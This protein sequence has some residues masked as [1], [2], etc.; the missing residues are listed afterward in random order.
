MPVSLY[1][2]GR[3]AKCPGE[4]RE[5]S[6]EDPNGRTRHKASRTKIGRRRTADEGVLL[7]RPSPRGEG[8][9][10]P[11]RGPLVSPAVTHYRVFCVMLLQC[12]RYILEMQPLWSITEN[13]RRR[14]VEPPAM[15]THV[16]VCDGTLNTQSYCSCFDFLAIVLDVISP[17]R[18][19]PR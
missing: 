8:R 15:N 7:R 2:D 5:R 9:R 4:A 1:T 14:V 11:R 3:V 18:L 17:P 19:R 12:P 6:T 16:T 10:N 13:S